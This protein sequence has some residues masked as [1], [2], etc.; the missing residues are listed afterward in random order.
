MRSVWHY[1]R[2]TDLYLLIIALCCSAYGSVLVYSATLSYETN[3]F[4][5][6]Q[7][8]A[9]ALGLAIFVIASLVDLETV[10]RYWKWFVGLNIV[11]QLLLIPFGS[12]Q[13]GNTSWITIGPLSIQPGELGKILFVFTF[14]AH[15]ARERDKLNHWQT[16]LQ[17]G[18]H[19]MV[20]TGIVIVTSGDV[21]M[22]LAYVAITAIMLFGAGLSLK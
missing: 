19:A 9:I 21:G 5:V 12:E 15:L 3:K 2:H 13:G 20:I 8:C 1:L 4:I 18:L 17:L 7:S 11:L 14:A 10:G 22:A 6:V 16:L